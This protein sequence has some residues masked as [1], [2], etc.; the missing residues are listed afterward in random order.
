MAKKGKKKSGKKSSAKQV[1]AQNKL[2]KCA[3]A[4][5]KSSKTG[6]YTAFVKKWFKEHP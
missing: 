6:K 1:K 2:A 5:Q 3:E 4:W